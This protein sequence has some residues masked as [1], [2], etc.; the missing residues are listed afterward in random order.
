MRSIAQERRRSREVRHARIRRRV[1]GSTEHP[2]LAVFRSLKHMYAQIIDDDA[3]RTLCAISSLE[4]GVAQSLGAEKARLKRSRLLGKLLAER[5]KE[6]GITRVT[7]DRGGY[8][9]HGHIKELAEGAREGGLQ[10]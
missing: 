2:R 4:K 8:L 10:F 5:A 6:K 3:A 1:H 9:Y 7:F